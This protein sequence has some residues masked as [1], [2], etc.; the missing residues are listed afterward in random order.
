M[1]KWTTVNSERFSKVSERFY[2]CCT[3]HVA[4]MLLYF[5]CWVCVLIF[6]SP[7]I[8][9]T[10]NSLPC[11]QMGLWLNSICVN[12][13]P[14]NMPLF[15]LMRCVHITQNSVQIAWESGNRMSVSRHYLR[16][17]YAFSP[18]LYLLLFE[19]A[20]HAHHSSKS[21]RFFGRKKRA[22]ERY[23]LYLCIAMR[24]RSLHVN[25]AANCLCVF[26]F[27]H[28]EFFNSFLWFAYVHI[29]T[30]FCKWQHRTHQDMIGMCSET[31]PMSQIMLFFVFV[32][33]VSIIY[34]PTEFAAQLLAQFEFT[35]EKR[36]VIC[37]VFIR[38][39][40]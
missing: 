25:R 6:L 33:F 17:T 36:K 19:T 10:W 4:F 40:I 12:Y 32:L 39:R 21:L 30:L 31:P 27:I 23:I 9:F 28:F 35:K 13:I 29:L 11:K 20:H 26:F 2:S 1:L 3:H 15:W 7:P 8:S 34:R 18:L 5:K 22:R 38:C 37:F 14:Q 24:S 16:Y